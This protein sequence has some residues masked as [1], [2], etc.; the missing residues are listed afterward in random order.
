VVAAW[1]LTASAWF[2]AAAPPDLFGAADADLREPLRRLSAS[3][4]AIDAQPLEASS[5]VRVEAVR[6][7]IAALEALAQGA[8]EYLRGGDVLQRLFAHAVLARS[9]ESLATAL[10]KAATPREARGAAREAWHGQVEAVIA[11]ALT[12]AG[13]HWRSCRDLALATGTGPEVGAAC[14]RR[15]AALP[16]AFGGADP[17]LAPG[18]PAAVARARSRELRPCF[19]AHALGRE[20]APAVE[21]TARLS[22]DSKGRVEA[23][24]LS[25]PPSD[26]A[27][28]ECLSGGLWLWVFPGAADLDI[29]V[30]LRLW[31]R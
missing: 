31:G 17:E 27:L 3:A 20:R 25:P 19:E 13:A 16:A 28:R 5:E 22:L 10:G 24:A 23:V 7:R 26:A 18:D 29:E 1:A 2:A 6:R 21:L 8:V 4:R 12:A 14:G 15:L 9:Q 30:P 11:R